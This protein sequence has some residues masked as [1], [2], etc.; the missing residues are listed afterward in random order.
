MKGEHDQQLD[1]D[2]NVAQPMKRST[3]RHPEVVAR[4]AR[5]IMPEVDTP[6]WQALVDKASAVF[7]RAVRDQAHLTEGLLRQLGLDDRSAHIYVAEDLTELAD[8][9]I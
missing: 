8:E 4:I 9:W 1:L 2:G 5:Q 6:E 3:I 7:K